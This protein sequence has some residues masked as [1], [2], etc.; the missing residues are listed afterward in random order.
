MTTAVVTT[1]GAHHLGTVDDYLGLTAD[2]RYNAAREHFP[3]W[4]LSEPIQFP[5]N[6][7][8]YGWACM[9]DECEGIPGSTTSVL[10]CVGHARQFSHRGDESSLEEFVC[11]AE[12][13]KAQS[14]GRALVRR[15]GCK[16]CGTN[17]ESYQ[18]G[19]CTAHS[20]RFRED[21]DSWA[22]EAAWQQTQRVLPPLRP[23]SIKGCVHDGQLGVRVGSEKHRLCRS[24]FQH[25][26]YRTKSARAECDQHVW[27]GWFTNACEGPTVA[28]FFRRGQ[29]SL[30][31]LPVSL[32]REIRYA[33]HRHAKTPRRAQWR[34]VELQKVANTLA[35]AGVQSLT[36]QLLANVAADSLAG[37]MERRILLDLPVAA[38][39]L[40]LSAQVSKEAG[41]FDPI[42][43][44]GAPFQGADV[45]NRRKP[46]DLTAVSQRWLR[47][48]LWDYLR[49]EALKPTGKRPVKGTINRR[50]NAISVLSYALRQVRDDRGDDP[51]AL[52]DRDANALKEI[53]D[54]WFHEQL[55]LPVFADHSKRERGVFNERVRHNYMSSSRI[56]LR[57]SRE[58]GRIP[59]NMDLFIFNLPDYPRPPRSPRPRPLT[60]SDFKVLVDPDNIG[61]LENADRDD[62]GLADIWLVQAFQGGRISET[63][64][65]RLGCVGLVGDAQPYIWRDIKKVNVVDYGMPCYLPVYQRLLERQNTTRV[66]LRRRYAD[67]LAQLDDRG[68]MALEAHWDREMPLF[69]AGVQN[70]DLVLEVSTCGFRDAWT[71]WFESLGLKGITTH[72]TRATLATS[73]LNNGAPAA[74]V[75]QLLGHFS[76][77]ALAHYANYNNDSMTRYLQQIW[78]A[79]PGMDK[80]GTILLR[81]AAMNADN[82]SAAAARIDLTAVPVEHGLC[83]YGP[84]VGGAHCPF[85]KNCSNGPQGPCE[86]FV[87]TGADLT[88]WQR[89][90]DAAYHFA[91]GAPNADARDYILSQWHS[92]EPVLNALRDALDELGLLEEA[93]KLDLRAPLHDYFDPLFSTGWQLTQLATAAPAPLAERKQ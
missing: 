12:P 1:T 8:T 81:P 64:Q 10:L 31:K 80:P 30:A 9:V 33:I 52:S 93:E 7:P 92:W 71:A 11:N 17:R 45:S 79:G 67:Q 90:R 37:S 14:F 51:L 3:A 4:L 35:Q 75:R 25:W 23:C 26:R 49:D 42:L 56:V 60:Y 55:P 87:L 40:V 77:E 19:Y 68:R 63:I 58:K 69:P 18:H 59:A 38:R 2:E 74:L 29:L 54:L 15:E 5:A 62:V 47:D 82:A 44:G 13:I 70:P 86:H 20:K 21:R 22:N 88:Y 83:R 43:V 46:W 50:I 73:L 34:P 76:S 61:L 65:L 91:E 89:K 78:A 27:I 53:S 36:D 24:H 85:G 39:S 72:Q 32:Q 48:L 16:I 57:E 84:V 41:W 28:P 6:H 66:R